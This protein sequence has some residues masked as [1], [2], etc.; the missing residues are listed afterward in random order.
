MDVATG[1]ASGSGDRPIVVFT[2]IPKTSGTS[3]RKALVEPNVPAALIY[4]YPGARRFL[5]ER[6]RG[7]AFIWGHVPYG[8]HVALRREVR[9][10]TFLRDPI[11]RAVSFYHFVKDSDPREYVHPARADAEAHSLVD[12]FRLRCYQNWQARFIAGFPYHYLYPRL[13]AGAFD[14][15]VGRRAIVHLRDEYVFGLQERFEDSLGLLERRLGW[16]RR[17]LA[18]RH[19][20]TGTRPGLESLDPGTVAALAES[21]RLD[22][23]LYRFAEVN[24]AGQVDAG[25]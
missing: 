14:A 8:V 4:P 25:S 3:F 5:A 15:E 9:Y 19:K 24:F 21:N 23:E 20:Q 22:C 1:R 2:H 10:V 11:D 7:R 17:P 6:R 18:D 16:S 13:D 12:F